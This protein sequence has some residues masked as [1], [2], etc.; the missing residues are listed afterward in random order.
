MTQ[1]KTG[2]AVENYYQTFNADKNVERMLYRDGYVLQGRELNDV[3][4]MNAYRLKNIADALFADGDVIRDA[5]ISVNAQTGEV[6]AQSGAVY[7]SGA[8]RGVSPATFIIPTTGTVAVGVRMKQRVVSEL[9]DPSLR[10]PALGCDG[11]GEPGAWRLVVETRWGF[12]GDG[13]GGDFFPVHTVD[14]GVVR[15]KEQPP[16][17]DSFTRSLAVYD[18]DSTGGGSYIVEGL[19][20]LRAEDAGGGGQ[21]YTVSEGRCRV[22]GYPVS[23]PTSRRLSYAA[24]PDLRRIDTEVHTADGSASQR[25]NVA[26][27][28]LHVV[29]SLRV[30]V[31]KE[32]TLT[33][34]SYSGCSDSLEETSVTSIVKVQQG[35]TV[36]EADTDYRKVGDK[37]D[38]SPLGNEPATGSTYK[39]TIQYITAQEPLERDCDGFSVVNGVAGSTIL[40][41]YQQAL[42]RLDRLCITQDGAFTWIKGVAS[43]NNPKSPPVPESMLAIATVTQTWRP[44]RPVASDGVYVVPFSDIEA[45]NRKVDYVIQE[46]ARQRLEADVTTRENGARVGMFVDPLLDDSMRDQGLEQSAAIVDGELTLPVAVSVYALSRD[47]AAPTARAYTPKVALAQTL[48]TG[49]MAVNPY[50]AFEPMPARVTLTP[51]VDHWTEVQSNFTSPVTQFIHTGHYVPGFWATR[52][53]SQSISTTTEVVGSTSSLLEYLRQIDVEFRIEGFG[54]GEILRKVTFDGIPVEFRE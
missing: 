53:V 4:E 47:V 9:E 8:V 14:D 1:A 17:L 32:V 11:E 41:T 50:Q 31:E 40:V 29:E 39:A 42:P 22:C 21:I 25:I 36:F 37:I 6:Q 15:A 43:E 38:W 51:S 46:V 3:Q 16:N 52:L 26:H 45:L 13:E 10:N 48:R 7:L 20:V 5:Q 2:V 18:R 30:T 34:G 19:S 28:P 49:S 24:Q 23:L 54:P 27:A 12:D 33:H 35:D 44:E